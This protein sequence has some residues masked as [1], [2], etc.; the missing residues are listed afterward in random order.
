[1][2][3][4]KNVVD[5]ADRLLA[6][7]LTLRQRLAVRLHLLICVHCRRY[8]HQLKLLLRALPHL[9]RRASEAEVDAVMA[10]IDRDGAAPRESR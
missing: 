5:D 10:R 8:L 1:M 6:G 7:E 4:C 3:S 2:L 9:R